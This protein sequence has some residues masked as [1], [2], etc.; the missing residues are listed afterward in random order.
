MRSGARTELIVKTVEAGAEGGKAALGLRCCAALLSCDGKTI[1]EITAT[2]LLLNV[3][4][5]VRAGE[6]TYTLDGLLKLCGLL[7]K[8]EVAMEVSKCLVLYS[9]WTTGRLRETEQAVREEKRRGEALME[10][11]TGKYAPGERVYVMKNSVYG[12]ENLFKI[13][14]TKDLTKRLQTYNTGNPEGDV[15]IIY[16]KRCCDSRLV[17]SMVHHILDSFRYEDNR[18][19]FRCDIRCIR[20]AIEHSVDG[21]DGF[22]NR[23]QGRPEPAVWRSF[24]CDPSGAVRSKYFAP[25]PRDNAK[26]LF[27]EKVRADA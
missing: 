27:R 7:G 24:F 23:L 19:Y 12:P 11:L 5:R 4:Y 3:D 20:D 21:T 25:T 6:P 15:T 14:R 10:K 26:V 1:L 18:E 22:R 17:E 2:G 16:E 8:P 9:R 13:G